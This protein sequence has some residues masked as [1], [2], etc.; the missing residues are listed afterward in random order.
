MGRAIGLVEGEFVGVSVGMMLGIKLEGLKEGMEDSAKV[1]EV[2]VGRLLGVIVLGRGVG[3]LEG[4]FDGI[5]V[6]FNMVGLSVVGIA[7]GIRTG[8]KEAITREGASEGRN[9]LLGVAEIAQP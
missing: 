9:C 8:S 1:G 7:K 5:D 4:F 2:V 6:G 3:N